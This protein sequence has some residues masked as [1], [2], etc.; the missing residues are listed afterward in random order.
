MSATSMGTA[1]RAVLQIKDG[2]PLVNGRPILTR[3]K[4]QRWGQRAHLPELTDAA[5]DEIA[6]QLNH[7]EL[8]GVFWKSEFSA[9]RNAN[10]STQRMRRIADALRVLRNDLPVVIND[11]RTVKPNADLTLTEALLDLAQKHQPIIDKYGHVRGR[12][13]ALQGNVAA[14]VGKL[15]CKL[16]DQNRIPK[17]AHD[18]FVAD[19]MAWLMQSPTSDDAISRNR[20]RR[21]KR[22]PITAHIGGEMHASRKV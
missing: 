5:A 13:R 14:N 1:N 10:P 4:V 19:A 11:S 3:K 21:K 12:P 22:A 16:C 8:M 2:G 7:A 17:K 20:R 18:A 6:C 9:F 15:V